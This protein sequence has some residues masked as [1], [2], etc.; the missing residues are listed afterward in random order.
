MDCRW[1]QGKITK[2]TVTAR[3]D[4]ELRIK[5]P[6]NLIPSGKATENGIYTAP[7]KKGESITFQ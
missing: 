2:V 5:L 1:E 4:A 3:R 7:L 6:E